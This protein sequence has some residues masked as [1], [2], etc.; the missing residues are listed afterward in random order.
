MSQERQYVKFL[1]H[2]LQPWGT[3]GCTQLIQCTSEERNTLHSICWLKQRPQPFWLKHN[4]QSEHSREKKWLLNKLICD[5]LSTKASNLRWGP[6]ICKMPRTHTVIF[7][8]TDLPQSC[9]QDIHSNFEWLPKCVAVLTVYFFYSLSY[10]V[11]LSPW[12][13]SGQTMWL[14]MVI[15]TQSLQGQHLTDLLELLSRWVTESKLKQLVCRAVLF[16]QLYLFCMY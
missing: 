8:F 12:F 4:Q 16:T 1:W 5:F 13:S 3:I 6:Y 7:L 2:L 14:R 9:T 10:H 15:M 11:Q